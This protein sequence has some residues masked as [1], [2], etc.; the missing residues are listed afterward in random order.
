MAVSD[1]IH[2]AIILA[3][4]RATRMGELADSTPKCLLEVGG[5][6]L[7]DH[8]V[9]ALRAAGI[10][11]IVVVVGHLHEQVRRHLGDAAEYIRNP[12]YATTNNLASFCCSEPAWGEPFLLLFADVLY[13]PEVLSRLQAADGDIVLAVSPRDCGEEEMRVEIDGGRVVTVSKD[14]PDE[15]TF[16]EFIGLARFTPAGA[17]RLCEVAA[18]RVLPANPNAWIAQALTEL[19]AA[20]G[21]VGYVDLGDLPYIEIDFPDELRRAEREVLPRIRGDAG[22]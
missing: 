4:G 11:R 13:H 2:T 22:P 15:R 14:L 20:G 19:A 6:C 8:S 18:A 10:G 16:G 9:R 12:H 17:R 7:L 3:A 21:H 1:K 5:V